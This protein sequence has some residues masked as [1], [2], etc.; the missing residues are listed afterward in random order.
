VRFEAIE[1]TESV[2]FFHVPATP[3]TDRLP[4]EL[5]FGAD[6]ARDARDSDAKPFKLID[7]RVDGVLQLEISP[8]HVDGDLA[9]QV[10]ART[11]VVTSRCCAPAPSGWRPS[12]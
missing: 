12:R 3:G 1:L 2:R 5:A 6:L 10:A 4:T 11:A 8:L 7:H 9:R